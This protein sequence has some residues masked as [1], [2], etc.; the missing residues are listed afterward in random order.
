[1]LG[2]MLV[3]TI[4]TDCIKKKRE[5]KKKKKEDF[6][7]FCQP[8]Q[9]ITCAHHGNH[10]QIIMSSGQSAAYACSSMLSS[11]AEVGM[12]LCFR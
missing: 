3:C 2:L 12:L 9:P 10:V 6:T 4:S 11:H 8:T 7:G 1:M 5:R